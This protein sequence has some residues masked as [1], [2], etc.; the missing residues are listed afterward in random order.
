MQK[1]FDE[2]RA[3]DLDQSDVHLWIFKR[4][5]SPARFTARYAQSDS[6]LGGLLRDV[7]RAE[8]QRITEFANYTYLSDTN[9]KSCLA[10]PLAENDFVHLKELVDRPE[11]DW[12]VRSTK[13]LNNASGYVAKFTHNKKTVYAVKQSAPNWRSK[14]SKKFINI[15]FREGE[16]SAVEDNSFSIERSFDF[17]VLD[18]VIF[19]AHKRA[20]EAV[21]RYRAA[22]TQAFSGLRSSADFSGLFTDMGPLVDYVGNNS[23]HLRRMAR[24]EERALF[25]QAQF[26]PRVKRVNAI[27]GWGLNFDE[28]SGQLIPCAQTAKVILQV[29]LDHRLLSEVTETTYDVP[30][31]TVV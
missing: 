13:D 22:Y 10:T 19:I 21:M 26:L 11:P 12:R 2:L 4:S 15:L 20:F 5:L 24:I 27:R 31:A 7:V 25:K 23:M 9:E 18:N 17:Y 29:L 1:T 16:L 30:D 14:Y 8:T 28:G 6:A 3:F